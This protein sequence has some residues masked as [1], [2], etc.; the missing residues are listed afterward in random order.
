M[1]RRRRRR[2]VNVQLRRNWENISSSPSPSFA[3]I[4]A[5]GGS[6]CCERPIDEIEAVA[7]MQIEKCLHRRARR[8]HDQLTVRI[9]RNLITQREELN[10][11]SIDSLFLAADKIIFDRKLSGRVCWEWSKPHE[12]Q[13]DQ[14]LLGTTALRAADPSIG[15]YQTL[16]I[17]SKPL[18]R[19]KQFNRDLLLSAFFHELI[20]CYLF[21][22]CGL[23]HAMH[24]DGHTAGFRKIARLIDK[25]FGHQRLHLCNMR[26]NLDHFRVR[27]E[28]G[29]M[30]PGVSFMGDEYEERVN[31][32]VY[33]FVQDIVGCGGL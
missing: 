28:R 15:G 3:P 24:S 10:D 32:P 1:S 27:E 31:S 20:H 19:D 12:R 8:R 17:L 29:C 16:I 23:P 33:V 7:V 18:L 11:D 9:L 2:P 30:S 21:I 13:Y 14:D 4:E 6:M 26:A 22:Q 5:C 25:S